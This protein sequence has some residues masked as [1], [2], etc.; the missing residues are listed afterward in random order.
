MTSVL[1]A[2]GGTELQH[3]IPCISTTPL[4]VHYTFLQ[5]S[6][7]TL[8]LQIWDGCND[9]EISITKCM[10]AIQTYDMPKGQ[11]K[12]ISIQGNK[13][14]SCYFLVSAVVR[15][16]LTSNPEV[17][18]M[19]NMSVKVTSHGNHERHVKQTSVGLVALSAKPSMLSN[20]L[21]SLVNPLRVTLILKWG[22]GTH[23]LQS[24]LEMTYNYELGVFRTYGEKKY[25]SQQLVYSNRKSKSIC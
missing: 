22:G 11:G 19:F 17:T 2:H 25:Q 4:Q 23:T 1:L 14:R 8:T 24:I 16:K 12:I 13:L 18:G 21:Q 5:F 15:Q 10:R 20:T 7:P 3:L 6:P 9:D